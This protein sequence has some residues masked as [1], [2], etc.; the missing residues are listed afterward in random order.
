MDSFSKGVWNVQNRFLNS[1]SGLEN[2][3]TGVN[4]HTKEGK[5]IKQGLV[6]NI[7]NLQGKIK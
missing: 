7:H 5:N 2:N 3:T 1:Q 4:I 6:F